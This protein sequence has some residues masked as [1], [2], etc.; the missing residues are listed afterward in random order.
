MFGP[1]HDTSQKTGH[2]MFRFTL[3]NVNRFSKFFHQTIPEMYNNCQCN[4]AKLH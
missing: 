3:A 1:I 2:L 4:T